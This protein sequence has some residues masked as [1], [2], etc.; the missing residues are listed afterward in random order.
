MPTFANEE[1]PPMVPFGT[2]KY[3]WGNVPSIDIIK[4]DDNEGASYDQDLK[5]LFAGL[6][7]QDR[8]WC[9]RAIR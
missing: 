7:A 3:L 1:L 2:R 9:R 5:I 8:Y 6:Q 4:L